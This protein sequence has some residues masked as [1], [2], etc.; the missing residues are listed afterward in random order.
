MIPR[1][2]AQGKVIDP[3]GWTKAKW[4]MKEA[5]VRT[6]FP[7]AKLIIDHGDS[8]LGLEHYEIGPIKYRVTFY[9]DKKGGGLNGVA[10]QAENGDAVQVV[11]AGAAKSA[12]LDALRDKY[13]EPT[14]AHAEPPSP[15]GVMRKWQWLMPQTGITLSYMDAPE[16][17]R[18]R[19]RAP[20]HALGVQ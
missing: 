2:I 17:G 4:G 12:L 18:P 7:A 9:F 5:Q 15:T 8:L 19:A 14:S 3:G 16:Y 10:L 1:R 20:F 13:G 6:A 11:Y